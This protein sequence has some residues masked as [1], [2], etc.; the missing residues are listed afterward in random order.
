MSNKGSIKSVSIDVHNERDKIDPGTPRK[1][2]RGEVQEAK[3][4]PLTIR[5]VCYTAP[6]CISSCFA[7][8]RMYETAIHLHIIVCRP[9]TEACAVFEQC[10]SH[11]LL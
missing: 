4:S 6:P 10:Y 9:Y 8:L 2:N 5:L 7:L 3:T 1:G 11:H